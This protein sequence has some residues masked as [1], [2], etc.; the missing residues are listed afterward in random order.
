M[1]SARETKVI[2]KRMAHIC[3]LNSPHSILEFLE[4]SSVQEKFRYRLSMV[5]IGRKKMRSTA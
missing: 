4:L 1:F 3:F 2:G 5:I